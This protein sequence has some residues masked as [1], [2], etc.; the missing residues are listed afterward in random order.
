MQKFTTDDGE[1]ITAAEQAASIVSGT[2]K[3]EYIGATKMISIRV[4]QHIA[5]RLQA[6]AHRS[7]KSRNAMICTLIDVGLEEVEKCLSEEVRHE[8][9]Q[10]EAGFNSGLIQ[11]GE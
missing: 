3:T 5:D 7:S 10:I 11:G 8:L 9:D 1:V 4:P 2:G 6:M